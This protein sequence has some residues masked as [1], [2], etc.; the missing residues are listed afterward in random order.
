MA[1]LPL[2]GATTL[3][4]GMLQNSPSRLDECCAPDDPLMPSDARSTI[5]TDVW[6]PNMY[7][8]LD[9]W[10]TISSIAP[11]V[12]STKLIDA[13]TLRP[14][15]AAPTDSATINDSEIGMSITRVSP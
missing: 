7:R 2:E 4:P 9:A 15:T 12:N 11:S 13:T 5:G 3:M 10:L 1:S 6:P 14:A 8:N